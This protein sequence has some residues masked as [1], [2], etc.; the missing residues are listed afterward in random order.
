LKYNEFRREHFT[1]SRECEYFTEKELRAQIGHE[2]GK[3]PLAILREL[4]DNSLDACELAGVAPVIDVQIKNDQITVSDNGPGIPEEILTKSMDYMVRV[5]DKA[6]YVSPT[7]GAM[8]NALKVVWAAPFVS[9]GSSVIEV[10]TRGE[11]HHIKVGLDL[12][13]GKPSIEHSREPFVKKGTFIKIEW[14]ESSQLTYE[15]FKRFLQTS[16]S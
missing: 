6:N 7:R 11:K 10:I 16:L 2:K 8:G 15:R 14:P 9:S 5:S 3:W 1:M 4:I 13:A 12:I